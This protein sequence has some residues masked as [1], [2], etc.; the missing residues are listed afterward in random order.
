MIIPLSKSNFMFTTRCETLYMYVKFR[1]FHIVCSATVV[2]KLRNFT[3]TILS[4]KFSESYVFAK[5]LYCNL[6]KK[7]SRGMAV[8]FSF[9]HTVI[10]RNMHSL[11]KGNLLSHFFEKKI[12]ESNSFT[13]KEFIWRNIVLVRVNFSLFQTVMWK[14]QTFTVT[15]KIF[16]KINK[17]YAY[18]LLFC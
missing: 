2:W 9:F 5:E 12:R 1:N 13:N 16:R 7:H 6:T 10:V 14:H 15:W 11:N 3:A 17:K 8:N 4:Q 18:F